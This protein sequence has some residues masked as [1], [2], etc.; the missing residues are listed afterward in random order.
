MRMYMEAAICDYLRE[1]ILP[2]LAPAPY[3]DI[4]M[5]RL[6]A[7]KP[8]CLFLEKKANIMVVGKQGIFKSKVASA[9]ARNGWG[10]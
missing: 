3:G 2:Q 6:A 7:Q 5:T 9:T 4:E 10:Y 8:V 1:E